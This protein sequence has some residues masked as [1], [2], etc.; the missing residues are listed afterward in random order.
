MHE[1]DQL[2]SFIWCWDKNITVGIACITNLWVR[3]IFKNIVMRR[4][5]QFGSGQ[6]SLIHARDI[7]QVQPHAGPFRNLGAVRSVK[8]NNELP[9]AFLSF[10]L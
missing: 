10:P 6:C 8:R 1:N 2:L 7:Q 5:D 3:R 4:R 9:F